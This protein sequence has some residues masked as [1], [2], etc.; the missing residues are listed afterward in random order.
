V[1]L[2]SGEVNARAQAGGQKDRGGESAGSHLS[3]NSSCQ[4]QG[5]NAMNFALRQVRRLASENL[6]AKSMLEKGPGLRSRKFVAAE[7]FQVA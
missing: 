3:H 1:A 6:T 2:L 5:Q 7:K 4:S